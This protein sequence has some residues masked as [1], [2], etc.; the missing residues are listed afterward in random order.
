MDFKRK[1]GFLPTPSTPPVNVPTAT[2]PAEPERDL[3]GDLRAKMAE[4]LERPQV[5]SRARPPA[6]P[7]ETSLPF[8]REETP[9][10]PLYRRHSILPPSHH[11][12]RIPVDAAFNSRPELLALLA[13][14]P[15]L[16]GLEVGRALFIDTET[17]GLGG[18]GAIAFL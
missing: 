1:L 4:I 7:T 13:L 6:D 17:T 3:L 15:A 9:N 10:G 2:L 14:D 16:S 11:V 8:V 12:G 5:Q 18:A